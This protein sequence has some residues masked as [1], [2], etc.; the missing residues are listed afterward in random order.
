MAVL[1]EDASRTVDACL[2]L[3]RMWT[4]DGAGRRP[5]TR[6]S[7]EPLAAIGRVAM[8]RGFGECNGAR[9]RPGGFEGQ[10]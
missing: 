10:R 4:V 9:S 7:A 8:G 2:R 5:S 1:A 6:A 3:A